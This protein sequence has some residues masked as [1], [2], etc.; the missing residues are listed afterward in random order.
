MLETLC[1]EPGQGSWAIRISQVSLHPQLSVEEADAQLVSNRDLLDQVTPAQSLGALRL[2]EWD[3]QQ[4]ASCEPGAG[5]HPM[6]CPSAILRSSDIFHRDTEVG[7]RGDNRKVSAPSLCGSG[8]KERRR[9]RREASEEAARSCDPSVIRRT[10]SHRK[11]VCDAPSGAAAGG[12]WAFL[13]L[14]PSVAVKPTRC[15]AHQNSLSLD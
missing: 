9:R 11:E 6:L 4:A 7:R 2:S 15:H 8:R 13:V 12:W 3:A 1:S 5:L 10:S 14:T